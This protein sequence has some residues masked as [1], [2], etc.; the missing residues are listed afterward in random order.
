MNWVATVMQ[1]MGQVLADTFT[2]P[3]FLA[4][5]GMIMLLVWWQNKRQHRLSAS[6]IH[7]Y[8][9]YSWQAALF[10][11]FLGLLGGLAGSI[12]LVFL[13]IDLGSISITALW[14]TALLLMM[15]RPRFI[16]F[17]YAA[18]VIAVCN[19]VWGVPHTSIPQLIGLVAALHMIESLLILLNG[20]FHPP[21]V[22]IKRHGQLCG[23]FNLQYF[24]PLPLLALISVGF[25]GTT[26]SL[27]MPAWWPLLR[28]YS[29][30][31]G[32]QVFTIVPVM[33][34]LG[35]GEIC[36]SRTPAQASRRSAL[37]L[38]LFSLLLLALAVFSVRIP[39]LLW[40]AAFFS[41][42]GHELVIWLGMREESRAPLYIQAAQGVKI[43]EVLRGSSAQKVGIKPGDTLLQAN[44]S[45]I[46]SFVQLQELLRNHRLPVALRI[47][48]AE[49]FIAMTWPPG[50]QRGRDIIPVPEPDTGT[51]LV[52][53]EDRYFHVARLLWRKLKGFLA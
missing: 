51:Y 35:Y 45:Q 47:K 31:S 17:A 46:E 14:L 18:G 9:D 22:Y 15:I 34:V 12:L 6:F 29:S 36:T 21:V 53:Q 8:P 11:S 20:T 3:F 41:P 44:G 26:P 33:A 27:E 37:L 39:A 2:S 25:P 32:Q 10:S 24:W 49:H 19:L 40:L 43:M 4:L 42:L 13:G 30:L 5:W 38:F 52:W 28:D 1:M 50:R 7:D 23:G 16:C 48:R